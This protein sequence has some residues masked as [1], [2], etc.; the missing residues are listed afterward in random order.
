[1]TVDASGNPTFGPTGATNW[2]VF[3]LGSSQFHLDELCGTGN[4]CATPKQLIIGPTD[5]SGVYSNANSS[6]LKPEHNPFLNQTATF[7]LTIAGLNTDSKITAAT[8]SFGTS[9]G[10]NVDGQSCPDCGATQQS[11]VPEPA[12]L[13]LLGSGLI[14]A[15]VRRWRNRRTAA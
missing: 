2:Q 1:V 7:N 5:G 14:G 12:S 9:A 13:A 15:G 10:I 3:S 8:F 4:G 6:I 11:T